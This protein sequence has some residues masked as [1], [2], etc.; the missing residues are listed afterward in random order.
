M[1]A[2]Q[3]VKVRFL[4]GLV[5]ESWGGVEVHSGQIELVWCLWWEGGCVCRALMQHH[6][7]DSCVYVHEQTV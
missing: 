6:R 2:L 4:E 7:L 1:D 3:E 5:L